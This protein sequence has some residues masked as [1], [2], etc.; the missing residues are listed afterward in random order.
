MTILTAFGQALT[1]VSTAQTAGTPSA[2]PHRGELELDRVERFAA[3]DGIAVP[4]RQ[5]PVAVALQPQDLE[6]LRE[7]V[8]EPHVRDVQH[9][10]CP[11]RGRTQTPTCG[12]KGVTRGDPG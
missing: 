4:R 9:D 5:D 3:H 11:G 8:D 10:L 6:R 12:R 2:S 1:Q 7:R